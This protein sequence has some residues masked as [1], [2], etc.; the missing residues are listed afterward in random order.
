MKSVTDI[1]GDLLVRLYK[2]YQTNINIPL[3]LPVPATR[4]EN[5]GFFCFCKVSQ[6]DVLFLFVQF[7]IHHYETSYCLL[8]FV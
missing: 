3:L 5:C 2:T 1:S 4:K 6:G 7:G 8:E